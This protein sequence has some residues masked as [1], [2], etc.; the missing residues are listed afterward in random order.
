MNNIHIRESAIGVLNTGVI[1]G[2]DSAITVIRSGG[3]EELAAG[4]TR[5]SEAIAESAA[6]S[7]NAKNEILEAISLLASEAVSPPD[8]RKKHV[9]LAL[10]ERVSSLVGTAANVAQIWNTVRDVLRPLFS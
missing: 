9:A 3:A 5:L 7:A 8:Q 4:I 6:L 10:I 2:L 1:S